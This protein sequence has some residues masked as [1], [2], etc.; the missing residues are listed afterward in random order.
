MILAVELISALLLG[1]VLGRIWQIRQQLLLAE[2]GRKRQ[3][4]LERRVV[5]QGVGR[6]QTTDRSP[7]M[8]SDRQN[9]ELAAAPASPLHFR[10]S[11]AVFA[12]RFRA[13]HNSL[14]YVGGSAFQH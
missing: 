8:P 1:F 4:P 11:P 14:H 9:E 13:L 12:G 6:S 3:H 2:P 10:T 5:H 7:S